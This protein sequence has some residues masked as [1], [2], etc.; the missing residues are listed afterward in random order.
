[1]LYH[2]VDCAMERAARLV[3][4]NLAGVMLQADL[5]KDSPAV[6]SAE[7]STFLKSFLLRPKV[8][9]YIKSYIEQQLGRRCVFVTGRDVNLVGAAAAAI[10]AGN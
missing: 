3:T 2:I 7:G 6:I 9:Q 1:M 4:A 5:G 8:E 10:I